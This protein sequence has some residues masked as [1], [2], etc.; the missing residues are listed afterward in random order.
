MSATDGIADTEASTPRNNRHPQRSA[1]HRLQTQPHHSN[2]YTGF[3][4]GSR[5]AASPTYPSRT[6]GAASN[7]GSLPDF[8]PVRPRGSS[9]R[10]F[11]LPTVHG[12]PDLSQPSRRGNVHASS[13]RYTATGLNHPFHLSNTLSGINNRNRQHAQRGSSPGPSRQSQSSGGSSAT[14]G[15]STAERRKR[16]QALRRLQERASKLTGSKALLPLFWHVRG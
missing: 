14:L 10:N 11:T 2:R 15:R 13:N 1:S 16:R 5:R 12:R 8:Q 3:F 4:G 7:S 6:T 9:N